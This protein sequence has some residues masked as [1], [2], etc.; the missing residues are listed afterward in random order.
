MSRENIWALLRGKG[1]SEKAAA[2]I[3]GHMEAESNCCCHR[4]Q[5]D[6][7]AGFAQSV[8]Y[9]RKVDSGAIS[10]YDF[11]N[12]GPGG[13]GYGA[14]QWTYPGRKDGMYG[15]KVALGES[16]GSERLAVEW[17]WD[18]LHQGEFQPVLRVLMS[19]ASIQEMSD[20]F[21]AGFERPADQSLSACA[22]RAALGAEMYRTYSG[23]ATA[24]N[25]GGETAASEPVQDGGAAQEGRT[26][27]DNWPPRMIQKGMSGFD[28]GVLRR[29][30][31]ALGYDCKV[32]ED[33]FD[34]RL[35]VMVMAYQGENGL[36]TD[37]V[38]G[39]MTWRSLGVS[40]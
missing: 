18:E 40:T 36:D 11:R 24:V 33:E 28:V 20:K 14:C 30:L 8:E 4:V 5:G 2:V 21:M 32:E 23:S 6:F 38:A 27:T 25:S 19:D 29:I 9:T 12:H 35:K 39:P 3:M 1:F 22:R 15:K 10:R 34:E 16:I 13:G 17:L 7:S 31:T 26:A 37:G